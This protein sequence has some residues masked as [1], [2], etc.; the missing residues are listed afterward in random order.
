[1]A[2]TAVPGQGSRTFPE[3]GKTVKGIFLSYWD[4]HGGLAQQ[5]FP[6]SEEMNEVSDLNGKSYTVQY[7]ERAVFEYHPEEQPPYDVLLSQ[8]GT[9]QYRKKY[10]N[11]APGQKANDSAGSQLFTETGHRVGGK[12]LAYWKSHGG[13]PQQGYPISEEFTEVS[14]LNGKT[15]TVQYFE[16]AVFEMHPAEQPPYDVLLSQ[17]G[18]FRY[19]EKYEQ[20]GATATPVTQ[21]STPTAPATVAPA[22]T[23]TP[24]PTS[25]P[26]QPSGETAEVVMQLAHPQLLTPWG[27]ALDAR[28]NIYTTSRDRVLKFNSEGVLVLAF[29]STGTGDGQFD[30]RC[31]N[32]P[33]YTCG[34]VAVDASSI[35]VADSNNSRVQKFDQDGHFLMAFGTK[36]PSEGQMLNPIDIGVDS[37]GNV[38][39]VDDVNLGVRKYGSDGHFAAMLAG[40]EGS[41]VQ[42]IEPVG[43]A[44]D[45]TGN[46][47]VVDDRLNSVFK[48]GDN[49]QLS[50][51]WGGSR[52]TGPGQFHF[53]FD[54]AADPQ[55]NVYV[56][57]GGSNKRVQ[58]F[59]SNGAWMMM[60][61]SSGEGPGQFT[62]PASIAVDAQGYV[63]VIEG[64]AQRLQKFRIK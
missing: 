63:Y 11:G 10:P 32:N 27:L 48:F 51:T 60:W 53:A 30:F 28:G 39:I 55:G 36:G 42:V 2:V 37:Q 45:N 20:S 15:Y 29:G 17:L 54:V 25:I 41:P 38:Y 1:V 21:V 61:G 19:R 24:Q 22:A 47:Y 58:K 44:V 46:V 33:I 62:D 4:T 3:T 6:I 5:G 14:E 16:R 56:M 49:G 13:L 7:F 18:T 52:G 57:E 12:F 9:F 23:P 34:A 64:V 50:L 31:Q 40:G 8:L 26:P 59:T 35:Y 43:L